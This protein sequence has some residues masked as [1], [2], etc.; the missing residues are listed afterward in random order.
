MRVVI[1]TN[2]V[3]SAILKDRN[4]QAV[5]LF[6]TRQPDFEWV[7]SAEILAEYV[8]V[9]QRK[10]FN[11]PEATIAQWLAF[12]GELIRVVPVKADPTPSTTS[13]P[14]PCFPRLPV[15]PKI[16]DEIVKS[17]ASATN[18]FASAPPKARLPADI[19]LPAPFDATKPVSTVRLPLIHTSTPT[20]PH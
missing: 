12:F 1:D 16:A 14:S 18:R 8:E 15:A 10:K 20:S 11:L 7:A 17:V 9:I 5:I 6:V 19:A 4:P 2:V 13:K 3:V